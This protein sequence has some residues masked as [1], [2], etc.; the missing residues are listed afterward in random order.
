MLH[1]LLKIVLILALA[2]AVGLGLYMVVESEFS[3]RFGGGGMSPGFS[4]LLSM[5]AKE[6]GGRVAPSFDE[7]R[8]SGRLPEGFNPGGDSEGLGGMP[9]GGGGT[10]GAGPFGG[11]GF[12]GPGGFGQ[13]SRGPAKLSQGFE[14]DRAGPEALRDLERLAI[15]VVVAVAIELPIAWASKQR[16]RG[17]KQ[18]A[19]A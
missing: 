19:A 3:M 4:W 17:R 2:L 7:M 10:S 18:A 16:R 15:A 6:N 1:K 5:R 12:G 13:G 8:V 9:F 14:P 11:G